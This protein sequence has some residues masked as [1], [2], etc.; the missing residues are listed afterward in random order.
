[1]ENIKGVLF[2]KDG[3]L[4]DFMATWGPAFRKAA[5]SFST[6]E[7][8]IDQMLAASGYDA[9]TERIL[10]GSILAQGSNR[11]IA[12]CWCQFIDREPTD[13][14][15]DELNDIFAS[16]TEQSVPVTDLGALFDELRSRGLKLGVATSDST[17]GAQRTMKTFGVTERLDFI[18][19]YDA[20]YGEK[21][22]A[23]MVNGFCQVTG[24]TPDQ[25]MVVGD[26]LHDID[27][28]RN[29]G[30]GFALGVLTGTSYREDLAPADAVLEDI[31]HI[32]ALLDH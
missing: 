22:S 23:G 4:I 30:A 16:F 12:E 27:M 15:A 13:G 8:V 6:D 28:A 17:Q 10:S 19:G 20:G 24:L 1:M 3:T 32:P 25:V 18:C 31:S 2:D 11:E 26:N 9:K 21:P 5:G 7:T 29:A 14:I